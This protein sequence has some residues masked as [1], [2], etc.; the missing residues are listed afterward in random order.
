MAAEAPGDRRQP[1]RDGAERRVSP[2]SKRPSP[3]APGGAPCVTVGRA[4]D[5]FFQRWLW[6]WL[7][8][9]LWQPSPRRHH[10]VQHLLI[11]SVSFPSDN[12]CLILQIN[13]LLLGRASDFLSPAPAPGIAPAQLSE[14]HQ[15]QQPQQPPGFPT[16]GLGPRQNCRDTLTPG[17]GGPQLA[18]PPAWTL[19]V[20]AGLGQK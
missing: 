9:C 6:L 3:R 17:A 10:L 16:A 18:N 15:L 14:S 7:I 4:T 19:T 8:C 20:Q 11:L 12:K 2:R 5:G 13:V 1:V